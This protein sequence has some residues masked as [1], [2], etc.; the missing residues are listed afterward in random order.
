MNRQEMW[1]IRV[2]FRIS[3]LWMWNICSETHHAVIA[4]HFFNVQLIKFNILVS[5]KIADLFGQH[6]AFWNGMLFSQGRFLPSVPL[7]LS[8]ANLCL[9][10]PPHSLACICCTWHRDR[11]RGPV[12]CCLTLASW[13][14][15]MRSN[16][17][18]VLPGPPRAGHER[19]V[20]GVCF[21]CL[22]F[23]CRAHVLPLCV[24]V[25][26]WLLYFTLAGG[27]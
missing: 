10:V 12:G 19:K 9:V 21:V 4:V 26:L 25:G 11:G 7:F 8:F 24:C 1:E 6:F 23:L 17:P 3:S 18:L 16:W 27:V 13:R 15:F 5:C 14:L 2:A 20:V 22:V